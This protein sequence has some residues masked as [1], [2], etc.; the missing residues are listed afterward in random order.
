MALVWEGYGDGG[1]NDA[2]GM[3][4]DRATDELGLHADRGS[5]R[6]RPGT[7]SC[8]SSAG[9]PEIGV[10]LIVVGSANLD[11]PGLEAVAREHPDLL[12]RER[13]DRGPSNVTYL[14]LHEEQGRSSPGPRPRFGVE[15]DALGS[16]AGPRFRSSIGSRPASPW[17]AN[18]PP[19]RRRTDRVPRG[20]RDARTRRLPGVRGPL[21]RLG[22][23][24]GPIRG[25]RRRRLRGCRLVRIR[26]LPRRR[27]LVAK[28]RPATLGDWRRRGQV[29][30][31]GGTRGGASGG[32]PRGVAS[33]LSDLDGQ[34][35][36]RGA[37]GGP[38]GP[39]RRDDRRRDAPLPPGRWSDGHHLQRWVHRRPPS[40]HRGPQGSDR[41]G[42]HHRAVSALDD[43]GRA[44]SS[45][46]PPSRA[47]SARS[48]SA[49]CSR[50]SLRP[51]TSRT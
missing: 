15:P 36:R 43:D 37:D 25:G 31:A 8:R 51:S 9:Y 7:R 19:G 41:R 32:D 42:R 35:I 27:A 48:S 6:S 44:R 10:G 3:G 46:S 39:R 18:R 5:S 40:G 49:T 29:R 38:A 33:A 47:W 4:F 24:R 1:W 14:V 16:S 11:L 17:R 50:S 12:R 2:I 22:G 30:D 21:D 20:R 28:A 34:A 26:G 23:R 13:R 45:P